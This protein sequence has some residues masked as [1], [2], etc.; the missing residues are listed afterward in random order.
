M[1]QA[2][3]SALAKPYRSQPSR[4]EL[5]GLAK[6][7]GVKGGVKSVEVAK[8]LSNT[9]VKVELEKLHVPQLT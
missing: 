4:E 5:A 1:A 6:Q 9:L 8:E 3:Q 2:R 7:H